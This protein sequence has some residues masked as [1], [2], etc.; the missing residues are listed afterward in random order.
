MN[1]LLDI[2]PGGHIARQRIVAVARWD[3]AP[4]RRAVNHA[5]KEG[6]LIDLTYGRACR[7]VFFLDSNHVVLGTKS[8]LFS[9]E[10]EKEQ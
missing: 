3:S 6:R 10:S 1:N 5:R 7:W 2:G 4:I 8:D 9:E